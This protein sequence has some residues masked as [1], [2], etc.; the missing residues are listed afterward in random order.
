M[1]KTYLYPLI[2]VDDYNKRNLSKMNSQ[3]CQKM[4]DGKN[5]ENIICQQPNSKNT[6]QKFTVDQKISHCNTQVREA[7]KE[8]IITGEKNNVAENNLVWPIIN[9]CTNGATEA[10]YERK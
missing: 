7:Y 3:V 10:N 1:F 9:H 8:P 2:I 4:M 5:Q 6:I